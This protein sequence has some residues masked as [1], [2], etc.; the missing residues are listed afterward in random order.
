VSKFA[1]I[2][3][4]LDKAAFCTIKRCHNEEISAK[5][6]F[7]Y[8]FIAGKGFNLHIKVLIRVTNTKIRLFPALCLLKHPQI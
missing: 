5:I 2:S 4:I 3:L 6:S 8:C 7:P 1:Y